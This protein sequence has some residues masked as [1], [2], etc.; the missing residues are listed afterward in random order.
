MFVGY[1]TSSLLLMVKMTELRVVWQPMGITQCVC[2][3]FC[4]VHRLLSRA[5]M[6]LWI[7]SGQPVPPRDRREH[8]ETDKEKRKV[9][10][11]IGKLIREM[12]NSQ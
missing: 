2:V 3:Y 9:L 12:A 11:A 6:S 10:P 5:V 4:H 8:D 1:I 7:E